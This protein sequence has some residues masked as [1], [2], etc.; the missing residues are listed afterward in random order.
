M[1]MPVKSK[2][3]PNN[4]F[5]KFFSSI[6]SKDPSSQ[7]TDSSHADIEISKP[8]QICS[9]QGSKLLKP[10]QNLLK[11]CPNYVFKCCSSFGAKDPSCS[12]ADIEVSNWETL[13]PVRN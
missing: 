12:H 7:Q 8:A 4:L 2:T 6:G 10:A 13:N 1:G 5:L 11:T 3:G 9:K